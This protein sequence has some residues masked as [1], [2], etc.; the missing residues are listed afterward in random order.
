MTRKFLPKFISIKF[1]IILITMF[2]VGVALLFTD[3][4]L[5][6]YDVFAFKRITRQKIATLAS[7]IGSNS[8]A[9][10][11][12]M[13]QAAA[14]EILSALRKSDS[15]ISGCLYTNYGNLFA[16][17]LR[18]ASKNGN[19]AS[20]CPEQAGELGFFFFR[21]T[22]T[23]SMPVLLNKE[24]IGTITLKTDLLEISNR[25]SQY[26]LALFI[27]F[28]ISAILAFWF[29][30]VFQKLIINPILQLASSARLISQ[31][32]DYSIRAAVKY[33]K[34]I[35]DEV[36][37]LIDAFND[38]LDKLQEGQEQLKE[39]VHTRDDFLLIAA[40]ELRTPM[41]P[42]KLNIQ[43]IDKMLKAKKPAESVL[44]IATI[45]NRQVDRFA[46]LIERLL[47]I[48][49][50]ASGQLKL[51]LEEVD[52]SSMVSEIIQRFKE[53]FTVSKCSYELSLQQPIIGQW[54]RLRLE[55]VII[56]LIDNALK[57]GKCKPVKISTWSIANSAYLAIEDHGIGM[58][59]EE[60]RRIF[61]MFERVVT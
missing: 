61:M 39:A 16:T 7:V 44:E 56:N 30:S 38:M 32:K 11:T 8:T 57:Y 59:A 5:I 36:T 14:I 26:A 23:H 33:D 47:D 29:L 48:S 40:H 10:I 3:T 21:D 6:V 27:T 28:I 50:I 58:T 1:K 37:L 15:I 24:R 20:F 19:K 18:E 22:L 4:A 41:T 43:L 46:M 31:K 60:Q 45:A 51:N 42:L 52:L 54:D 25:L 9:A 49:R 55:Q 34:K 17:Y 53:E 2:T 12:F 35:S 13:D